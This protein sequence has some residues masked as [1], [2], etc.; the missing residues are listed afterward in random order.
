MYKSFN[1]YLQHGKRYEHIAVGELQRRGLPYIFNPDIRG[2]DLVSAP[3]GRYPAVEIKSDTSS[4]QAHDQDN[5][6]VL[7]R[8]QR[9]TP[10]GR[11]RGPWA[12]KDPEAYIV[13]MYDT[14]RY[15]GI[16]AF[17]A[18][19]LREEL[20]ALIAKKQYAKREDNSMGLYWIPLESQKVLYYFPLQDIRNS[21]MCWESMDDLAEEL[22][23]R[24]KKVLC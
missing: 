2:V 10:G 19:E 4:K 11:D 21:L 3:R 24:E 8:V 12:V 6:P 17:R 18:R 1:T 9:Y 14:G 16:F 22:H 15:R 13:Y 5:V 20:D 23:S 7:L